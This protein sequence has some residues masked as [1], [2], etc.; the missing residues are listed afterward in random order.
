[1]FRVVVWVAPQHVIVYVTPSAE[2]NR[3]IKVMSLGWSGPVVP[4]ISMPYVQAILWTSL[5]KGLL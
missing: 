4:A 5:I 3:L 1:M 2:L